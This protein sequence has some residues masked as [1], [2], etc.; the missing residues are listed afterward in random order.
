LDV[1]FFKRCTVEDEDDD[2]LLGVE[3]ID[4]FF[5][6]WV[7]ASWWFHAE[8]MVTKYGDLMDFNGI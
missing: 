3:A 5:H 1:L 4:L 2:G 8:N 7:K 6:V